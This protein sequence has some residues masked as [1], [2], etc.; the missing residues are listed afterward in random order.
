MD[1]TNINK[2]INDFEAQFQ[3]IL[4]DYTGTE[5]FRQMVEDA[6][7]N[8]WSRWGITRDNNPE[9]F[10]FFDLFYGPL[11]QISDDWK[12]EMY[13]DE[14]TCSWKIRVSTVCD[15]SHHFNTLSLSYMIFGYNGYN[16]YRGEYGEMIE[17]AIKRCIDQVIYKIY[18]EVN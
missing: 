11:G 15:N 18:K 3:K 12:L 2:A 6:K 8:R 5:K 14:L 1:P 7:E 10:E 17:R 4:Q 16:R 9:A 13:N